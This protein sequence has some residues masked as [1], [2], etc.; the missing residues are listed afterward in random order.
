MGD[1]V[2]NVAVIGKTSLMPVA[3]PVTLDNSDVKYL[4]EHSFRE[5]AVREEWSIE[6]DVSDCTMFTVTHHDQGNINLTS[7]DEVQA[8]FD[9][10]L[11]A[12]SEVL[13][14]S[15][16]KESI[17]KV[18]PFIRQIGTADVKAFFAEGDSG[19]VV[20]W[21]NPSFR[22]NR[23]DEQLGRLLF[24]NAVMVNGPSASPVHPV[25]RNVMGSLD[26]IN[27]GFHTE[28]FVSLFSLVDDLVQEVMK[29]GMRKQGIN[30]KAQ[31][32]NL[33]AIKEERLKVYLCKLAKRYDWISLEE[34]DKEFF[35]S[36]LRVNTIRNR[37]VHGN[38]KLS[39]NDAIENSNILLKLIDWLRSN[40]Y[41]YCIP[42]FPPLRIAAPD[43]VH[44]PLK[45]AHS[46][47]K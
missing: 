39:K 24:G 1:L 40:P 5:R 34:F 35:N 7:R 10:S 2:T 25:L 31:R 30:T 17:G 19:D 18:S 41:E 22:S 36:V 47:G 26:L 20:R 45:T 28:S 38:R 32:S 33:R 13:I 21:E 29:A 15:K 4:V 11:S 46:D 37:I 16:T 14:W 23:V 3:L 43:F 9:Q 8:A 27:L 12:I 42:K 44:H 6:V